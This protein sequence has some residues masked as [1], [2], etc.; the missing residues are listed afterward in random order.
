MDRLKRE[1]SDNTHHPCPRRFFLKLLAIFGTLW[2]RPAYA[3][4]L[5]KLLTSDENIKKIQKI[6]EGTGSILTSATELDYESELTIG[7]SIAHN[8]FDRFGL[9]IKNNQIQKYVNLVGNAVSRNSDRP[10]TF[11]YFVVISS[12]LYNA[13]ACPGGI[14]FVT[15]ALINAMEDESQLA[16]VLS[17][18]VAH[19]TH[20]H[21]L[22]SIRR[23]KFFEGIGKITAATTG[24][25]KGELYEEMIDSLQTVLFDRG[26]DKNM[27]FEADITGMDIAYRTG[28]DP[29]GIIEV[30]KKLKL[31]KSGAKKDGSWFSTHPPLSDRLERCHKQ[32]A[33]YRDAK[34]MARVKI[35]FLQ[36]RNQL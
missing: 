2:I 34:E 8:G 7:K 15:T 19:I 18:E 33:H 14:I 11:Y 17:H 31:K 16:G 22:K 35:R 13:F 27:E 10:D 36:I 3:I 6:L 21:A 25:E 4:D 12:Q 1:S 32:M 9:P 5:L 28:Y 30:L 24:S 26:L 29:R 23:A 20:K